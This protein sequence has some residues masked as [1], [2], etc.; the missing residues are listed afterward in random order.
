MGW[1]A[2]PP[3]MSEWHDKETYKSLIQIGTSALRFVLL[4]NGGAAIAVLALIGN[5]YEP[6][7]L[8]PNLA[9]SLAWFL[10]GMVGGGAAHVT[11]YVTQLFYTMKI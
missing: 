6:D 3:N 10:S 8:V 4:A 9:P 2:N 7:I 5:I 11:A 1:I